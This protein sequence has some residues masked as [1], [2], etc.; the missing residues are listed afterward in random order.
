MSFQYG[1]LSGVSQGSNL[2]PLLNIF[3]TN[4]VE[5]ID[6]ECLL[7]ADDVKI[8]SDIS[9][10]SDCEYLSRNLDCQSNCIP[11]KMYNSMSPSANMS[12]KQ[13][14]LMIT[15]FIIKYSKNQFI[16]PTFDRNLTFIDHIEATVLSAIQAHGLPAQQS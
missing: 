16:L 2:G 7:Y 14:L 15:F 10:I 12:I 4:L 5:V 11:L 6:V 1:S 13:I 8:F 9:N 3:I